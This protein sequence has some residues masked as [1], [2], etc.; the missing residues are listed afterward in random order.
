MMFPKILSIKSGSK[1]IVIARQIRQQ[2]H[3]CIFLRNFGLTNRFSIFHGFMENSIRPSGGGKNGS[4]L[5]SVLPL[6]RGSSSASSL[7]S[8]SILSLTFPF[9]SG[10][11]FLVLSNNSIQNVFSSSNLGSKSYHVSNYLR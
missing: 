4:L 8:I 1:K 11:P 7:R 5:G 9:I 6:P 3:F 10:F 2:K